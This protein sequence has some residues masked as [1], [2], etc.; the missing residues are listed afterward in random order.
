MSNYVSVRAVGVSIKDNKILVQREENGNEYALPGGTVEF[1]E[2]TTE[3]LR[4][5]H[6][7]ELGTDIKIHRLL[8]V[9]ESFWKAGENTHHTIA[10]YYL[11]ELLD[12]S[13]IPDGQEFVSQKDNCNILLGWVPIENIKNLTIY[14]RFLKDELNNLN[15][16]IKH[17]I[18]R[19]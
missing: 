15:G 3:T 18:T 11:V 9:E 2:S 13:Y 16:E 7:E 6:I 14:P 5:E 8:W 12:D 10:F 17:F 19:E 4:R 1:G